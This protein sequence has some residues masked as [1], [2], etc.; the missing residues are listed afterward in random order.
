MSKQDL[1]LLTVMSW[2]EFVPLAT[3][4]GVPRASTLE[5]SKRLLATPAVTV[6]WVSE[7]LHGRAI[8]LL[9]ARRDKDYSLCDAVS[10]ILMREHKV[11][12]ALTSDRHFEQEGFRRLL[13]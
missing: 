13:S 5:F 3:V 2:P 8:D 10:F 9:S 6:V 12:D 11:L 1:V 7:S 4:R